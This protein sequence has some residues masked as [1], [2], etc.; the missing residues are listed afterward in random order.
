MHLLQDRI[1]EDFLD[2]PSILSGYDYYDEMMHNHVRK[3]FGNYEFLKIPLTNLFPSLSYIKPASCNLILETFEY[4][5][6]I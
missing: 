5:K 4:L 1:L 2:E 3:L 6:I